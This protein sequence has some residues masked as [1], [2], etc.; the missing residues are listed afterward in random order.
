MDSNSMLAFGFSKETWTWIGAILKKKNYLLTLV[1]DM[2]TTSKS[3]RR[4]TSQWRTAGCAPTHVHLTLVQKSKYWGSTVRMCGNNKCETPLSNYLEVLLYF[5]KHPWCLISL[6]PA[7]QTPREAGW[8][9]P[10]QPSSC[11]QCFH[12][13]LELCCQR[14]VDERG[15]GMRTGGGAG[16]PWKVLEIGIFAGVECA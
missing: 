10:P 16:C 12:P 2:L 13:A 9:V 6:M 7:Q 15:G 1:S 14:L 3:C 11:M 4:T 8:A 5:W